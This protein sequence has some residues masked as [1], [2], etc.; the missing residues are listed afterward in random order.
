MTAEEI[1]AFALRMVSFT[2][3]LIDEF[4]TEHPE[5]DAFVEV[6]ERAVRVVLEDELGEYTYA[7]VVVSLDAARAARA[8][9]AR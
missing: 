9:R 5:A 4:A 1:D 7:N 3:K 2:R 6:L 8:Q